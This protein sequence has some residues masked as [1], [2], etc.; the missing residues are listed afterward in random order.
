LYVL[1]TRVAYGKKKLK[2]MEEDGK[3]WEAENGA[4]GGGH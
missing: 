1:I 4:H 2:Q 3:R